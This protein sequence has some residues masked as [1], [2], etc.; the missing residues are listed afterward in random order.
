MS[1]NLRA[2]K[3]AGQKSEELE[4]MMV[5]TDG[6]GETEGDYSVCSSAINKE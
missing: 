5:G 6:R 3:A 2:R 4:K 1:K